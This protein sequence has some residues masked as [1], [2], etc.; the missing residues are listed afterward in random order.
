MGEG[1]GGCAARDRT[2]DLLERQIVWFQAQLVKPVEPAPSPPPPA[3]PP[4]VKVTQW[5]KDVAGNEYGLTPDGE[6]DS[7]EN[8]EAAS[9][10]LESMVNGRAPYP[11]E[12]PAPGEGG[13]A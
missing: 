6:L 13:K 11:A 8:I 10:M 7:R 5:I 12:E 1:C 9:R 3:L 4:D 2:I